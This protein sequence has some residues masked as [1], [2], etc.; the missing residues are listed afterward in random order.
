MLKKKNN[1]INWGY[2]L[3]GSVC[4]CVCQL[5]SNFPVSFFEDILYFL[6]PFPF[7]HLIKRGFEP[8]GGTGGTERSDKRKREETERLER[9]DS[10]NI[11]LVTT[12]VSTSVSPL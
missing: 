7:S 8:L 12:S 4:A 6:F 9:R 5:I 10:T 1:S 3:T 2:R 11:I